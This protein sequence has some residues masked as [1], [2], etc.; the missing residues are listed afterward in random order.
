M[1]AKRYQSQQTTKC[2]WVQ[3]HHMGTERALCPQACFLQIYV[4]K[5][6]CEIFL[7]EIL[8]MVI[9]LSTKAQIF[10]SPVVVC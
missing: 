3:S 6:M 7:V 8:Q 9:R 5:T 2:V 10:S 1:L 4:P